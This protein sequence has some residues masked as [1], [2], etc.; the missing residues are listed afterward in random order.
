[1]FCLA[2][3]IPP[4][5]DNLKLKPFIPEMYSNCISFLFQSLDRLLG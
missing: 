2:L 4:S 5:M 1:M 3:E